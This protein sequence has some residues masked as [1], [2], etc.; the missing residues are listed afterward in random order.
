MAKEY[1][2]CLRCGS[3]MAACVC[4]EDPRAYP[5]IQRLESENAQL[6]QHIAEL[7][8]RERERFKEAQSRVRP[9][10]ELCKQHGNASTGDWI[11]PHDCVFLELKQRIAELGTKQAALI[12]QTCACCRNPDNDGGFSSVCEAH[13]A[14]RDGAIGK[15]TAALESQLQSKEAELQALKAKDW[16]KPTANEA[17]NEIAAQEKRRGRNDGR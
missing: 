13:E 17:I 3:D 5:V 16:L 11:S 9:S 12:D 6:K 8:S 10:D 4:P 7:E 14:W 2:F 15:R 1:P